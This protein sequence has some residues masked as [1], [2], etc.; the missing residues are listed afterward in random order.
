M[1]TKTQKIYRDG[2]ESTCNVQ[3]LGLIPGLGRHPWRRAW[4]STPVFLP[5]EPPYTEEP[6]GLQSMRSQRDTTEQLS[7]AHIHM[8]MYVYLCIYVKL[9]FVQEYRKVVVKNKRNSW[10]LYKLYVDRVEAKAKGLS[11]SFHYLY[12]F[13]LFISLLVAP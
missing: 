5:G 6:G 7:T 8:F 10:K 9:V 12:L 2:K 3:D 4:Q 11:R 13:H 1:T